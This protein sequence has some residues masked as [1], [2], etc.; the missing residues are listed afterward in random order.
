MK[1]LA[2]PAIVCLTLPGA[3]LAQ[4]T[5]TRPA[6]DTLA[7]AAAKTTAAA[8][9]PVPV[10]T[11]ATSAPAP[12]PAPAPTSDETLLPLTGA[13][14]V[15][16]SASVSA[17]AAA[18]AAA[19]SPERPDP[20]PVNSSFPSVTFGVLTFLQYQAQLHESNGYNAFD[21]TR[22]YLN[23]QARLSDR[24]RV[25]FTPDVRPTT[26]ASLNQNLALRLEYASLDVQATDNIA[27]MFGLHEMPWLAF[28]ETVNRYRVVGPFF[29]ER[30]GLIPG[31]TDLGISLERSTE[32]TD[33]HV[34][35][36]NGEGQGRAE[37]DK[38]KSIDGRA[39]FRPFSQDS[40]LGKVTIS[41]FYQYGWYARD[42][43]RNVAIAMGSYENDNLVLTGQYLSATDNPF[44][45]VD[46]E[47][48]G[49]SFFGEGRQGPTGWSVIGGLDLFD[50]DGSNDSDSQRRLIVG[51]AH[52]SQISRARLGV[53]VSLEQT[54]QTSNSQLLGRRLLAQTHI[55]F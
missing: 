21:V 25:R 43:P 9:T 42:R 19:Q 11:A 4:T 39:T 24:I 45:A 46:I 44:V 47:R 35:V 37:I 5:A 29:S 27:I 12:A 10:R 14:P 30:L 32:R 6:T 50:P 41:G 31:T 17:A 52:W 36:Y 26:D 28:E 38:Y 13:T 40:E 20:A 51:G 34:G 3:A 33:F 18:A 53:V 55:E 2:L 48:R 1:R 23:I 8:A 22:G 15:P 7:R 16:E 49:F 54:H